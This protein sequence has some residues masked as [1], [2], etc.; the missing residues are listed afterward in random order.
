MRD[1]LETEGFE[2]FKGCNCQGGRYQFKH[3]ERPGI[4]V[5]IA[6]RHMTF[7]IKQGFKVVSRGQSGQLQ[8]ELIRLFE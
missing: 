8:S 5:A 1:L 2:Q 3:A 7:E 6:L 4:T